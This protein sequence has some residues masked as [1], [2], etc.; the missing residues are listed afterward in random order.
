MGLLDSY[1]SF[2]DSVFLEQASQMLHV[3][4]SENLYNNKIIKPTVNTS[5]SLLLL[6]DYVFLI[7]V[8]IAYYELTADESKLF[9]A[10]ELT[11]F[12]LDT[13]S[14]EDEFILNFQ[15]IMLN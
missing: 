15:K 1:K 8:L 3:L 14:S 4:I 13:F 10:K 2:E 12:T 5:E 6:E 7:D 9:L 11:D